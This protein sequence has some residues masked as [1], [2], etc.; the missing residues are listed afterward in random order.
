MV[1]LVPENPL[2]PPWVCMISKLSMNTAKRAMNEYAQGLRNPM[3]ISRIATYFMS[4]MSHG[5]RMREVQEVSNALLDALEDHDPQL[6]LVPQQAG[7]HDHVSLPYPS[8]RD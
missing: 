5:L 7:D 3:F 1:P 6:H 8:C 2:T 4:F